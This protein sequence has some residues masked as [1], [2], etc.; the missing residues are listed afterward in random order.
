MRWS[1]H[2]VVGFLIVLPCLGEEPPSI[3]A[4][5]PGESFRGV[6]PD[7]FLDLST[8]II[9]PTTSGQRPTISGFQ[10]RFPG[11]FPGVNAAELD[12]F[13]GFSDDQDNSAFGLDVALG[14]RFATAGE[15]ILRY[16]PTYGIRHRVLANGDPV[17]TRFLLDLYGGDNPAPDSANDG[18]IEVLKG[19]PDPLGAVGYRTEL[20]LHVLDLAYGYSLSNWGPFEFRASA[21]GRFGSLRLSDRSDGVGI[22]SESR[23]TFTGLGPVGSLGVDWLFNSV[24]R[25]S[26]DVGTTFRVDGGVL[27]GRSSQRAKEEV[28]RPGTISFRSVEN[29][30]TRA[31]P[32]YSLQL[33]GIVRS[34]ERRIG[35]SAGYQVEQWRDVS[36]GLHITTHGLFVRI[37]LNY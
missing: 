8:S 26:W 2:I 10:P 7:W 1:V 5:T 3:P 18:E 21:G 30:S 15:I 12:G 16:R 27:F 13:S 35:I 25:L 37:S 23:T 6:Q 34:A 29:S 9:F 32:M 11:R 31:V 22:S 19:G 17:G 36:P 4:P 20:A 28:F 33:G 24:D 14:Y